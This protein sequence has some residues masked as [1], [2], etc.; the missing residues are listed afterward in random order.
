MASRKPPVGPP[1]QPPP[2]PGSQS[3]LATLAELAAPGPVVLKANKCHPALN[4]LCHEIFNIINKMTTQE[5][6]AVIANARVLFTSASIM[7]DIN[8]L[9]TL[10]APATVNL[11]EEATKRVAKRKRT[12]TE[13]DTDAI[14]VKD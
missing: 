11:L 8:T 1:T 6:E 9:S 4:A 13:T 5:A 3:K 2:P 14:V 10:D 7:H 12:E